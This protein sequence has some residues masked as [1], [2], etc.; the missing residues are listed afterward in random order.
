MAAGPEVPAGPCGDGRW[1]EKGLC[2]GH[3]APGPGAGILE[4]KC[5]TARQ[6]NP[7]PVMRAAGGWHNPENGPNQ[8]NPEIRNHSLALAW[9]TQGDRQKK[10]DDGHGK[11][12]KPIRH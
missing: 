9:T 1:E 12:E 2:G 5:L 4:K 7:G 8:L 3:G 10:Q 11:N 6:T